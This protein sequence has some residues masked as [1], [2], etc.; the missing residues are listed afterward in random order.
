MADRWGAGEL[1]EPYMG[2]WS[3][4]IAARFVAMVP[5]AAGLEWVDVGC[6]TGALSAA[7]IDSAAPRSVIGLDPSA[8]FVEHA[9]TLITDDRFT[10]GVADA[11]DLGLP[12]ES[13]DVA[14]SGLVLNFVPLPV[15]ALEEARRVVRPGG[16]VGGYVW[17]YAEGMGM[18]RT[19]WDAAIQLDPDAGEAAEGGRFPLC[20]PEPLRHALEDAGLTGIEVG[21]I[22]STARFDSFDDYWNPFLGGQGPAGGYLVRLGD[23]A[24]SALRTRLREQ[25]PI[26]ADGA[27][28]LPLRAWTFWGRV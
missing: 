11:L 12:S 27:I 9:R 1:Y 20:R 6:G 18:L 10:V 24:R 25:L 16:L 5:V 15:P 2:R 23:D 4:V 7:V 21:A 26:A 17:D 14:V 3:R 19:F 22:D 8:G 13:A 28:E